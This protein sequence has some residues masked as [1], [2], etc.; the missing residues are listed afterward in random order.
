MARSGEARSGTVRY[1]KVRSGLDIR[2]YVAWNSGARRGM[3]RR[4]RAR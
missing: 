3:A 2:V 4:G 1:G